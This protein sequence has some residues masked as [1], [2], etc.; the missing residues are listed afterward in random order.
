MNRQ[1]HEGANFSYEVERAFRMAAEGNFDSASDI[2][3]ELLEKLTAQHVEDRV[4]TRALYERLRVIGAC[5]YFGTATQREDLVASSLAVY[6]DAYSGIDPEQEFTTRALLVTIEQGADDELLTR[7]KSASLIAVL[8]E[9]P[10]SDAVDQMLR[11]GEI[12][13]HGFLCRLLH[14]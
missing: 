14:S 4:E 2:V 13:E 12:K 11:K 10:F 9:A 8:G 6:R 5:V 3:S 1:G 7:A